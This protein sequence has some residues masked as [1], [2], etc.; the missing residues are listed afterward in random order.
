MEELRQKILYLRDVKGLSF[1]QIEEQTGV[2]RKRA[3]KICQMS[4]TGGRKKRFSQLDK[5]HPL[6]SNWFREY[7]SLKA[8]QVYK[9]L[10]ERGVTISYPL[11]VKYTK[12][13]RRKKEKVYHPL[14]FLSGEEA[15]VDW[16]IIPHPR[17]GRLFCFVL[18]LSYSR[19]LFAHIF[20]R[21]SFEFFIEGHIMAF[22]SMNGTAHSLRYDNLKTVVIK[23]RPEIQYNPRFM[24]FVRHYGVEIRLCNPACGNEKGRV[25]RVIRTMK[26]TFFNNTDRY[27]SLSAIN[28]GLHEWVTDKNNTLHRSTGKSPVELFKEETIKL[29][30]AIPWKNVNIHPPVKTTKTA[31]IIF[32]T[33]TYSVPDY[34]VGRSLSIHST[35]ATVK[36]YDGNREV[37]SHPRCFERYKQIIN[38]LHRSYSKLSAKAK[39]QRIYD[40]IRGLH[41]DV[42]EFLSKNQACG[43]DPQK[44]AYQIFKL[45]KQ[46]SRGMLLSIVSECLMRKSP[47]LKTLLSY[48]HM[49]EA[50]DNNA[51]CPQNPDLLNITY[52][53]RA[54]EEY[55]DEPK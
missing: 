25:E 18:I 37:S 30:P 46:F 31:M 13:L 8:L 22:S 6:I 52:K 38:P 12:E 21:S 51:V 36:I 45:L 42:S 35:P 9:W 3:S 26:T 2:S 47:R 11:V 34:L 28:Q 24:D 32:D 20:P 40:V 17:M 7:P 50:E 39:M 41:P 16:C 48:L 15:Q 49:H 19:Y 55:E 44:T 54:L 10:R 33:N 14:D 5:Y 43:E 27:S 23:R 29:L 4:S 53:A 1:Y